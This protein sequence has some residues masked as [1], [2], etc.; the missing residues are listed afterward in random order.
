M[1]TYEKGQEINIHKFFVALL[2]QS[3][4]AQFDHS[5]G[6]TFLAVWSSREKARE[7]LRIQGVSM[8]T[9]RILKMS[10][11]QLDRFSKGIGLR[12]LILDA[13]HT[14]ERFVWFYLRDLSIQ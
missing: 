9:V 4:I 14:D 13:S 3:G 2:G 5:D 12:K 8:S 10:A 11:R 6:T 1:I 7:F